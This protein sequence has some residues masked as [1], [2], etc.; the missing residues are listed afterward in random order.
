M[1]WQEY[2][3]FPLKVDEYCT[4]ITWDANSQRAFDWLINATLEQKQQLV[5]VI[6]GVHSDKKFKNKF[7]RDG[8]HIYS[9]APELKDTPI[10]RIRGWGYLTGT[11]GCHLDHKTAAQIQDA[12]GDYI[13]EQLNKNING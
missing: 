7:Y 10:L 3:K 1:K 11:G 6:N 13:I 5:D 12:F 2:Y 4:I 8:I 9:K